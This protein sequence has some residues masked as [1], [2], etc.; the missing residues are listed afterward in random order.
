MVASGRTR[1]LIP[2]LLSMPWPG[3]H[4]P[5]TEEGI[6]RGLRR[7]SRATWAGRHILDVAGK[8]WGRGFTAA[9]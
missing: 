6:G 3:L 9:S 5:S 1:I 2:E 8:G 7:L 4:N